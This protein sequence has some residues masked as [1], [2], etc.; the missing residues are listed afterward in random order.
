MVWWC[1]RSDKAKE[2]PWHIA[3]ASAVGAAGLAASALAAHSPF[4]SVVAITFG[5]AGTLAVLPIFWTLPAARLS[6][7]AAAG[8]IALINAV[9][10][11]GGFVGPYA[12]GWIKQATGDFTYGLLA[13][14]AGVLATGLVALAIG[15]DAKAEH[16]EP[17]A[18]EGSAA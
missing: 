2:R 18:V 10:N 6:G 12:V 7:A 14:A 9:G 16:G 4:L 3:A 11:V 13:L 5:A 15:H 8:G 17:R 1:R